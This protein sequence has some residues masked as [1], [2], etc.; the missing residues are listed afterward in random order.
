MTT[1]EKF[2]IVCIGYNI[3]FDDK[4][5]DY[6][7]HKNLLKIYDNHHKTIPFE[8]YVRNFYNN[9]L[10]YL[11]Q[12]LQTIEGECQP[13]HLLN[14]CFND[15]EKKHFGVKYKGYWFFLSHSRNT[16][17]MKLSVNEFSTKNQDKDGTTYLTSY[18]TNNPNILTMNVGRI[19]TSKLDEYIKLFM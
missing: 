8:E 3:Y 6:I 7:L 13:L 11:F 1:L 18:S 15:K 10:E 4:P 5:I 17:A 2:K 9:P 12:L 16:F 14:N 19:R